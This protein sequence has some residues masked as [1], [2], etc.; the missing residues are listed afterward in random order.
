MPLPGVW[1]FWVLIWFVIFLD[2]LLQFKSHEIISFIS[3]P[4]LPWTTVFSFSYQ[5]PI[6][7]LHVFANYCI[8]RWHDHTTA[9]GNVRRHLSCDSKTHPFSE[10]INWDYI[11]RV[12][13]HIVLII[14]CSPQHNSSTTASSQVSPYSAKEPI[15]YKIGIFYHAVTTKTLLNFMIFI[16]ALPIH[17]VKTSDVPPYELNI[18]PRW[19]TFPPSGLQKCAPDREQAG[20]GRSNFVEEPKIRKKRKRFVNMV[21]FSVVHMFIKK[22]KNLSLTIYQIEVVRAWR[23][24]LYCAWWVPKFILSDRI[25]SVTDERVSSDYK[26][27]FLDT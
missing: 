14:R 16:H 6:L 20:I 21:S 7:Q 4:R 3:L 18:S 26:P 2:L 19:Q 25:F 8:D 22:R 1:Q 15:W 10:N 12:T 5:S 11:N 24:S 17:A 23:H 13:P 9:N 27:E